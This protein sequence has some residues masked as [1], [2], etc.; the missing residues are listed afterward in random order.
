MR[1]DMAPVLGS[2]CHFFLLKKP[3]LTNPVGLT[4]IQYGAYWRVATAGP[5]DGEPGEG[6]PT[7]FWNDTI[8]IWQPLPSHNSGGP[9]G[10]GLLGNGMNGGNATAPQDDGYYG[11]FG[12][13]GKDWVALVFMTFGVSSSVPGR[14]DD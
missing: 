12:W 4:L 14:I 10:P 7:M 5:P 6:Q 3:I 13:N 9:P 11:D 8:S 2:V 1:R